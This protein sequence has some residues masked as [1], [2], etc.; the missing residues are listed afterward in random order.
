MTVSVIMRNQRA[1]GAPNLAVESKS[2]IWLIALSAGD[3]G[4]GRNVFDAEPQ[5]DEDGGASGARRRLVQAGATPLTWVAFL[6][7]LQRDWARTATVPDATE[8]LMQH[9]GSI[10]SALAWEYRLLGEGAGV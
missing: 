4:G 3:R 8:I 2:P 5:R 6:A 10:G 7:E 9:G 1:I